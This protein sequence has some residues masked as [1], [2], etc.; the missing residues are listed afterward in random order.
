[1][2]DADSDEPELVTL[3]LS[4]VA[5]PVDAPDRDGPR[6]AVVDRRSAVDDA[7]TLDHDVGDAT[8]GPSGLR[9]GGGPGAG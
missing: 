1:V 8:G 4:G 9:P 2:D 3:D 6:S 7:P 5:E